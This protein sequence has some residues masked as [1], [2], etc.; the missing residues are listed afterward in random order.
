MSKLINELKPKDSKK[1]KD[2]I[3]LLSVMSAFAVLMLHSNRCFNQFSYDRYWFTSNII[4]CICYPAVPIFFMITGANLLDYQDKY[5]TKEY[6]KK[7]LTKAFIPYVAWTFVFLVYR[8]IIKELSFSDLSFKFIFNGLENGSIMSYY[9]FFAPLFSVYLSIPLFA[10]VS[11]EKRTKVFTYLVVAGFF[12]NAFIPFISK[13]FNLGLSSNIFV[14]VSYNYLLYAMLGYL[15][16]KN[17]LSKR[18]RIRIYVLGIA[19]LLM[20]IIGIYLFSIKKGA[21]DETFGSYVGVPCILYATSIFVFIK[22]LCKKIKIWNIINILSK[23]T[24][25]FYLMHYLVIDLTRV[26]FEPNIKSI[27]YRLGMPLIIIPL[28]MLVTFLLRKIPIVKKI[29]P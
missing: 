15:I 10:A 25:E 1:R 6:F 8:L 7:R 14:I 5:S 18:W 20:R 23:Y 28:V 21:I 2:Y 27:Y 16:D 13:V 19:S 17:E 12:I 26:F 9:W 24:F 4:C 22:Q 29:V 3:T 11:K